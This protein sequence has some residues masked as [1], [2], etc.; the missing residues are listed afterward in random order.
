MLTH[1]TLTRAQR[2]R[3][4]PRTKRIVD[5][6]KPLTHPT[7]LRARRPPTK[8]RTK[9]VSNAIASPTAVDDLV[10]TPPAADDNDE[11]R[12]HEGKEA[13]PL[14]YSK[15]LRSG[16]TIPGRAEANSAAS[17]EKEG[18]YDKA[19][20]AAPEVKVTSWSN[21]SPD[22]GNCFVASTPTI[23]DG[24]HSATGGAVRAVPKSA[25]L[26][27][28]RKQR[29]G[30]DHAERLARAQ[31]YCD[32]VLGTSLA[33]GDEAAFV[34]ALVDGTVLCRLVGAIQQR[35]AVRVHACSAATPLGKWRQSLR[36]VEELRAACIEIGVDE[37]SL[38]GIHH[39]EKRAVGPII[40]CVLAMAD[41]SRARARRARGH[42]IASSCVPARSNLDVGSWLDRP[43]ADVTA[44]VTNPE[45]PSSRTSTARRPA[46]ERG[47][48]QRRRRRRGGLGGQALAARSS[49]RLVRAALVCAALGQG[50]RRGHARQRWQRRNERDH[51]WPRDRRGR[52]RRRRRAR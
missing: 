11:P 1:P 26:S 7:L 25:R 47:H 50:G 24:P 10:V 18:V 4:K 13:S 36:N 40:E 39:L 35:R 34:D 38:I 2:P 12:Q 30:E 6:P 20:A 28:D 15:L 16:R 46:A 48:D 21:D 19:D 8:P 51:R 45:P 3:T 23:G 22:D 37:R 41:V 31:E 33:G 43:A 14:T 52:R 5:L 17:L 49:L 42:P 32:D 29:Q 44:F 9:R 27:E